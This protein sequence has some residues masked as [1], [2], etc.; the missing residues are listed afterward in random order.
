MS[1]AAPVAAP[2][3]KTFRTARHTTHYLEAGP[4]DGPLMIFLHGWPEQGIIW[5][6]QMGAFATQGWRCIAPDMR[7][8]GGSSIPADPAAY[9]H[10][11][12]VADMVE[13][14]EHLGGKPAVWVGHDWGSVL[15]GAFAAHEPQRVRGAV[16]V[17]VPYFPTGNAL[18][19]L[20]PLVDRTIYPADTYPD[21]Q[22]DYYRWYTT[23]FTTA[24][25]DLNADKASSLASIY[26]RGDP[27]MMGKPAANAKVTRQGGRFG[28]A[29]RAP[30]TQPDLALWPAED[31]AALVQSF[32]RNGFGGPCSWYL[33]D[34][35]NIA[36][37]RRSHS[38]ARL[39]MPVLFVNGDWDQM[40]SIVGNRYGEPMR[41]ACADL[42]V[43]R[44]KGAHWLPLE[45]KAELVDAIA[46]WIKAKA[47]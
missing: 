10:Q 42:T 40:N 6:A 18:P 38:G 4:I 14:H 7:G 46:E 15:V 37:M 41:A 27:A 33:N 11:E 26:R 39:S 19:T 43:T 21:G 16:L 8:Y 5:R 31:F 17:S 9:A 25:A 1:W 30:A 3:S 22:W 47:L 13:L 44:L 12:V 45:R 23:H 24:V 34:D 20:V 36:Y 32:E 28:A 29:H 2:V 35:A